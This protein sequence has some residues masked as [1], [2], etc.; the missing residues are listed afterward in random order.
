MYSKLKLYLKRYQII[1]KLD[2]LLL[3]MKKLQEAIK[4]PKN[5]AIKQDLINLHFDLSSEL[6]DYIEYLKGNQ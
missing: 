4:E 1:W 2:Q 3:S 5:A 6:T